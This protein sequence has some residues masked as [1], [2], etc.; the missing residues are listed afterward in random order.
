M[1]TKT[2]AILGSSVDLFSNNRFIGHAAGKIVMV[3]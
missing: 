3:I 2:A 1:F